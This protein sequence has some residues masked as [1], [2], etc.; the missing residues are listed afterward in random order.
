VV[1]L[2]EPRIVL[3][4]TV[5]PVEPGDLALA[6]PALAPDAVRTRLDAARS[7]LA[8]LAEARA[9]LGAQAASAEARA[10]EAR[11]TREHV[12]ATI[13][14]YRVAASLDAVLSGTLRRMTALMEERGAR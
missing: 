1:T 12:S 9:L 2:W 13:E 5:T 3:P 8:S 7:V 10:W 4:P 14:T 6:G 11:S